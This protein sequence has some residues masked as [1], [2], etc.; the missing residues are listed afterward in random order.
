MTLDK[1]IND[2]YTTYQ[3]EQDAAHEA[4]RLAAEQ[5]FANTRTTTER[6]LEGELGDL[7]ALLSNFSVVES[8]TAEFYDGEMHWDIVRHPN[9]VTDHWTISAEMNHFH[10]CTQNVSSGKLQQ[11]LIL[12]MGIVRADRQRD[13][14]KLH[15]LQLE[16][17]ELDL[18]QQ[19]RLDQ[20]NQQDEVIDA[21]IQAGKDEAR[22]NAWTWPQGVQ[23]VYYKV[24]WNTGS[25][26][27]GELEFNHGYTLEHE[28]RAGWIELIDHRGTRSLRLDMQAHKPIWERFAVS[29]TE[30]L[31]YGLRNAVPVRVEGIDRVTVDGAWHWTF[32]ENSGMNFELDDLEVPLQWVTLAVEALK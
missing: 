7:I 32:V 6:E 12:K 24:T 30:D 17:A 28:L 10:Y 16:R 26:S 3:A 1:L 2:S 18:K 27:D 29:R 15:R 19:Q 25:N 21:M 31:E 11:M 20:L 13:L 22:R 4:K 5:E 23:L 14:E 9:R 8:T